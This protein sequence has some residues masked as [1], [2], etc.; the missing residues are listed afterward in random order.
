MQEGQLPGGPFAL[1]TLDLHA[2]S[3]LPRKLDKTNKKDDG[4][5]QVKI[6]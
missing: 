5:A 2:S 3:T 4:L 6:L 1:G